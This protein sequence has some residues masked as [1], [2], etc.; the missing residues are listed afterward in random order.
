MTPI[1]AEKRTNIKFVDSTKIL[2]WTEEENGK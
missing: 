1:G 2:W